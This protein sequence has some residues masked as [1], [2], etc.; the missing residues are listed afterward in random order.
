ME[1]EKYGGEKRQRTSDFGGDSMIL[2]VGG[3]FQSRPE[4]G[5]GVFLGPPGNFSR[6]SESCF[7]FFLPGSGKIGIGIMFFCMFC[8]VCMSVPI[9]VHYYYIYYY[10]VLLYLC[11][12]LSFLFI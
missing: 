10:Y 7:W 8:C 11:L 4:I 2:W 6:E 3:T 12:D 5:T 9:C 1:S